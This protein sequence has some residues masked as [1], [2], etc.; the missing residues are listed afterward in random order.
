MR[1]RLSCSPQRP[2]RAT[3]LL[4]WLIAAALVFGWTTR[5]TADAPAWMHALVNVP[6]PAHDDK[7]EAVVLYSETNVT[8]LGVDKIRAQ[9]REAIKI[10]RPEGRNRGTVWVY[11]NSHRRV[12]SLHGWCIPAEGKDYEVKDKDSMETSPPMIEGAELIQDVK[13][14][15]LHIQLQILATLSATN[16]K[17]RRSRSS[18]RIRGPFRLRIRCAKVTTPFSSRPAGSTSQLG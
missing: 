5:A 10:L 1:D 18:C 8:V 13:L 12:K 11:L 2:R 6:L 15:V 17:S 14:R 3:D 4:P 9:V 7:A 16:T